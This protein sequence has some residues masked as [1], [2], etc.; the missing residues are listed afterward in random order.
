MKKLVFIQA[1]A[2]VFVTLLLAGC[3]SKTTETK[4][5]TETDTK[6]ATE[7]KTDTE[8]AKTY[9]WKLVSPMPPGAFANRQVSDFAKTLEQ[10]TDGRIKI[11]LFEGT[12]GA[13]GDAWDMTKNNTAQLFWTTNAYNLN[14]MPVTNMIELPFELTSD[15]VTSVI[16]HEWLKAGYLKEITDNFKVLGFMPIQPQTL[17]L[18]DK[19][20]TT[21][22]DLKGLKIRAASGLQAQT[23]T[24]LGATGVTMAGS[25]VYMSLDRGVIDGMLTAID[26]AYDRKFNEVTKYVLKQPYFSAGL[27]ILS[28]NKET[29]DSLP[30][31]LQQI[32]EQAAQDAEAAQLK[33]MENDAQK[34]W[35]SYGQKAEIY[36]ISNEEQAKWSQAA[37]AASEKYV[38]DQAA[39]G[40]PTKEALALMRKIVSENK[41]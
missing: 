41:K 34:W 1:I 31:D 6:T 9:N 14:R 30:P 3:S 4:T 21:M 8:S 2:L 16:A 36:T 5:A 40:Y 18:R 13:P 28:M 12:L 20:V 11:T 32:V 24:S 22:K 29:W 35:D 23:L 10:R 15:K 38:Q 17:F 26:N 37:L 33:T 19:K 39:K 25:E 7:P 27:F